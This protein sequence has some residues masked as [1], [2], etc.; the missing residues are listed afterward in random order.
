MRNNNYS[1]TPIRYRTR[2]D[3]KLDVYVTHR[4]KGVVQYHMGQ[5]DTQ[6]CAEETVNGGDLRA[7]KGGIFTLPVKQFDARYA[8]AR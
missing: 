2:G 8:P 6:G 1:N 7:P 5:D 3:L 4:G